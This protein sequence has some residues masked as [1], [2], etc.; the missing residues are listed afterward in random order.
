MADADKKRKNADGE[1]ATRV[2]EALRISEDVAKIVAAI[3]LVAMNLRG[4]APGHPAVQAAA[5]QMAQQINQV[6]ETTESLEVDITE[7]GM[8]YRTVPLYDVA[9]LV[10]DLV[11]LCQRRKIGRITFLP[12]VDDKEAR[13]FVSVLWKSD[14]TDAEVEDVAK[15]LDDLGVTHL[16]IERGQL[17]E[18]ELDILDRAEEEEGERTA[19]KIS[20]PKMLYRA[21]VEVVKET[22]NQVRLE[23]QVDIQNLN[24]LALDVGLFVA[25]DHTAL[26][27]FASVRR[28]EDY[29]YTHPVNVCILATSVVA[30]AIADRRQLPEFAK[31]AL[32]FDIGE[33]VI[34][35]DGAHTSQETN[36]TDKQGLREHPL[37]GA[38]VLDSIEGLGK[39]T[40]VAAFEHHMGNDFS[41]YPKVK[42][43]WRQN[44]FTSILAV[45]DQYDTLT[46]KR[47]GSKALSPDAALLH[48]QTE[49][50]TKF[51][52]TAFDAFVATVGPFPRGSLVELATGAIGIVTGP[53]KDPSV[54]K[55]KLVTD[56]DKR[57]VD[58][59]ELI[60]AAL[61]GTKTASP[62]IRRALDANAV[63]MKVMDYL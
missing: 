63:P 30:E 34:P 48:M 5:E 6:L 9:E 20:D 4:Y 33:A 51:D 38:E 14:K 25:R 35:A 13:T 24:S 7:R 54:L 28:F 58:D 18:D 42:R 44:I 1:A 26:L 40:M 37:R 17:E 32:L 61:P 15:Q 52:R 16:V 39:I 47:G 49:V 46:T 21:L 10:Q 45:A 12:G 43:R 11:G 31:S 57:L 53:D 59:P 41:G 27:P 19:P 55:V 50:G 62:S 29:L 36:E 60:S 3:R 22:M 56:D 8:E 23:D 2:R